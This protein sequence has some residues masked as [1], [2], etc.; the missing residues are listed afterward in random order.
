MIKKKCLYCGKRF[1][2]SNHS[3]KYCSSKCGERYRSEKYQGQE[4]IRKPKTSM[5]FWNYVVKLQN[6]TGKTY[7][8]LVVAGKI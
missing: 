5:D 7:G 1:E 6:E 3:Q 4:K 8:E 2:A